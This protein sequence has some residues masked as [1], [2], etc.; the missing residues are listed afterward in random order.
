VKRCFHRNRLS[1]ESFSIDKDKLLPLIWPFRSA[2]GGSPRCITK[3][4]R[5][6]ASDISSSLGAMVPASLTRQVAKSSRGEHPTITF[7]ALRAPKPEKENDS[8]D[9]IG[10][11]CCW[12]PSWE[13]FF[14]FWFRRTQCVNVIVGCSPRE[15]FAT[16]PGKRGWN[17]CASDDDM[18]LAPYLDPFVMQTW[19]TSAGKNRNGN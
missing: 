6:G 13:S 3:G 11:S 18:S 17:H 2:R 16:L 14:F 5:Y 8:Q 4:S 9:V 15:D 12:L 1:R 7:H 19:T 10:R